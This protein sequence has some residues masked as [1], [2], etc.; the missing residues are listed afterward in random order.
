MKLFWVYLR[1]ALLFHLQSES[2]ARCRATMRTEDEGVYSMT[3]EE[4]ANAYASHRKQM[5]GKGFY[6]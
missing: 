4:L 1:H 6:L 5:P 2:F 3:V